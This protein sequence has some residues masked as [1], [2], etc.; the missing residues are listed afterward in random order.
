[1]GNILGARKHNIRALKSFR[2]C[3]LENFRDSF[4]IRVRLCK[5]VPFPRKKRRRDPLPD[6]CEG[7][8]GKGEK[9]RLNW[10]VYN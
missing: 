7:R 8:G 3:T 1:M 9:H 6:F 5:T 2:N 10:G 4:R